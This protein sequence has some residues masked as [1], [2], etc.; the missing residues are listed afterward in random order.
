MRPQERSSRG[1]TILL[2]VAVCVAGL[3]ACRFFL[4]TVDI[5]FTAD[6]TSLAA[7]ECTTLRWHVPQADNVELNEQSINPSGQMEVCPT[8]TT[9]Y[10]LRA[11]SDDADQRELTIVVDG[12]AGPPTEETPASTEAPTPTRTPT[13][14]STPTKT[15][16]PSLTFTFNPTS[17]PPGSD[18]E[19]Y[20]SAP[21]PVTVYYNGQ[22]LPKVVLAGGSTLRVTIPGNATSGYFE[23]R[24][25]GQSAHA[26]QQ[27]TVTPTTAT[28]TLNN[29]SGQ[30]IWYVYISLSTDPTWGDDWLGADVIPAG[31]SYV[32]S[33]PPGTYDLKAE[34]SGH[35]MIGQALWGVTLSGSYTWNVLP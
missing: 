6:R 24:Y 35:N 14:T 22:V 19:L 11:G 3:M 17:G 29:Q 23:L 27:F 15:P 31:G 8:E 12:E 30:A 25:D 1:N 4:G 20:L 26:T 2:G 18:V 10:L 32:F 7:G 5:T 33:V 9:T 28:V 13:A 21:V 16:V 34:G